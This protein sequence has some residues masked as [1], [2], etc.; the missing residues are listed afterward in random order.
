MQ[1]VQAKGRQRITMARIQ[2][3]LILLARGATINEVA[4]QV[5]ISTTTVLAWMD[6]CSGR[7]GA[8]EELA[9]AGQ[10]KLSPGERAQLWERID[11][12]QRKRRRRLGVRE[13][14]TKSS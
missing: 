12:R 13:M 1:S 9:G 2:P 11:R 4:E 10:L 14:L 5:G 3:A 8:I 7:R 6:W